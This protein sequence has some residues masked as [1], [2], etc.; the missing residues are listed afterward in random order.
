MSTPVPANGVFTRL[1]ESHVSVCKPEYARP[2]LVTITVKL[3]A[4]KSFPT[5]RVCPFLI[6]AC[7]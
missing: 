4:Q 6:R 3:V 5:R 2:V 7:V 1:Y